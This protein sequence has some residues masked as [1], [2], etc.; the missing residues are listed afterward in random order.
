MASL[1]YSESI[2]CR[3]IFSKG[4][5]DSEGVCEVGVSET[6]YDQVFEESL[7]E[8][9]LFQVNYQS[10]RLVIEDNPKEGWIPVIDDLKV[11]AKDIKK[12]S[13]KNRKNIEKVTACVAGATGL[14][15]EVVVP[16]VTCITGGVLSSGGLLASICSVYCAGSSVGVGVLIENV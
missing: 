8:D 2:G 7:L 16:C 15:S 14:T 5:L 10:Y 9:D 11:L 1:A 4:K 6:I 13:N 3:L 12:T